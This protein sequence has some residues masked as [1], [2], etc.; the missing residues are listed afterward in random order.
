[1]MPGMKT[2]LIVSDAASPQCNGVVRTIETTIG[3]LEK[4]GWRV[5]F[6]HPGMF[7]TIP[8]PGYP[9]I[10]LPISTKGLAKEMIDA[11]PDFVHIATEGRLG[12]AARR[13]CRQWEWRFT[14][15]YHTD[16]PGY[17]KKHF[18]ISKAIT[19]RVM[20]RFH[21]ASS[22]IMVATPTV[23][24]QLLQ[25]GFAHIRRWSRGVDMGT[26]RP[27]ITPR[28]NEVPV[29]LN[30]GRVSKEK[31]LEAFFDIDIPSTKI[32]VGDGPMLAEYRERYPDVIFMGK[33]TG[34]A[35]AAVYSNAD[36]FVF[37][38]TTD[39]FGLV[40]I[41]AMASGTPVAAY[42]VQGPI[43]ILCGDSGRYGSDLTES[44]IASLALDREGVARAG[45][46]FTWEH[47][48]EQFVSALVPRQ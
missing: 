44:V 28:T 40:I 4:L 31:N 48:T 32:V 22:A 10:R 18:G 33:L 19:T 17:L 1:M 46:M 35:L 42:P 39:T 21:D 20:R 7:P 16:F 29:L 15:A 26:F 9:E 30:V 8:M 23:E 3:V 34:E 14:T 47:A 43:D 27:R 36:V 38:S 25:D 5:K 6:I 11:S 13:L 41:E 45:Q 24:N 37:P 12:W 2:L